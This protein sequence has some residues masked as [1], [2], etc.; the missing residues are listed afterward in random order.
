MASILDE[1]HARHDADAASW[2][3][4]IGALGVRAAGSDPITPADALA[5]LEKAEAFGTNVLERRGYAVP[6][7]QRV[8]DYVDTLRD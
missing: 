8:A 2:H 5:I 4:I 7:R 3:Y 6:E 1:F